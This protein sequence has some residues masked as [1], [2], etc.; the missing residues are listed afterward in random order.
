M[1]NEGH[2]IIKRGSGK[3]DIRRFFSPVDK[4]SNRPAMCYPRRTQTLREETNTMQKNLDMNMVEPTRKMIYEQKLKE[5]TDRLKDLDGSK[6]KAV[7]IIN[8]DKDGWAKRRNDLGTFIAEST[9]TRE[10][11]R[12]R[13]VNPHKVLR[14][15]KEGIKGQMPLGQART[16]YKIISRALQAAGDFEE[17][18]TSFLQK[19]K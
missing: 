18:N 12:L 11:E 8:E 19:E 2:I 7:Q 3:R 16:E 13:R 4:G 17:S 14:A 1:A 6:E 9:P 10:D 5:K 15:E